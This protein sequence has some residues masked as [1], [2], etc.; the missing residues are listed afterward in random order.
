MKLPTEFTPKFISVLR[1]GITKAQLKQDILAGVIVGIVALPLAIAFAIASGVSPEKGLITAIFAGFIISILGGS[2]VQIGGPT[3]AFIVIVLGIVQKYGVEGLTTATLIAGFML[4][5][6]GLLRF[7]S[8][9]KYIP[10]PLVVGFTSGIAVIIFSTQIRDFL[11]L[12]IEKVPSEFIEKWIAY[13]EHI[14]SLNIIAV[15]IGLATILITVFMPKITTKIPGSLAAIILCTLVVQLFHLPIDTIETKFGEIPNTLPRPQFRIL[16][17]S[18]IKS[19]LSPAFAIAILGSIESLLSAVVADGMIGSKHRSNMEL[20]AQGFANIVSALVGGIPATGA[21]ARTATN[22]KNG[23]RTPIAG[24]VH[25]LVLLIIMLVAAPYAKL[26]PLACLAGI[27]IVVAY[28][29]SEWHL[30]K[31][32]YKGNFY[33]RVVLLTVFTLTV[34]FDLIIAIE[35]G[36]VLS[37]FLF[38]KRM[39]DITQVNVL[40]T[41][42]DEDH[43]ITGLPKG[44]MI[45]EITGALFFGATQTFQEALKQTNQK[46]EAIILNFKNVPLIDATGL[47]RLEEIVK[48]FQKQGTL[49][50]L[51]EFLPTVKAEI[52]QTEIGKLAILHPALSF[53]I[54]DAKEKLKIV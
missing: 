54:N 8:L 50:Y 40:G 41:Q 37:A 24:I 26:I 35:I 9:L 20:V 33:D 52:I 23:G 2:R 17:F 36:M 51:T 14:Q 45:Y 29:M 15:L 30:F 12:H 44:I 53:C 27:L 42:S 28:N 6:M 48:Q 25:A 1:E 38:I 10:H 47:Y 43:I 3:G 31:S 4:L 34:V 22:V 5:A 7:G 39:S 16:S 49:I 18:Q 32:V 11:G 19:L 21:I 13:G 46:P